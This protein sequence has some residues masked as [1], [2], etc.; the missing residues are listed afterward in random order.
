MKLAV[1]FGFI[2]I[3]A[4]FQFAYADVKLLTLTEIEKSSD[5]HLKPPQKDSVLG[6][7]LLR[8]PRTHHK[9]FKYGHGGGNVCNQCG[10]NHGGG[11]GGY[12]S[13]GGYYS[14]YPVGGVSGSFSQ[15]SSQSSSSSFGYGK[16]K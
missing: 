13:H 14:G 4:L 10:G 3:V 16:K 7:Q 1:V 15:S 11:Y 12:P 5:L 9:K 6:E 2:T 8:L